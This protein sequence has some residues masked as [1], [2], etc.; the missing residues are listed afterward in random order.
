MSGASAAGPVRDP[1]HDPAPPT[2][3]LQA[4]L[5]GDAAA[6]EESAALVRVVDTPESR[7]RH[8]SDLLGMVVSAVGVTL[9]LVLSVVAHATTEGVTQDVQGFNTLLG[10][11]LF[12]PVQL[13]EGLVVLFVP[14][15]VLIELGVRRL[16]R[17][18]VESICAAA[19]GLLLGIVAGVLVVRLGSDELVRGLSVWRDG[20]WRLTI[21]GYVA[22]IAGLLT[23]AG[24][25]TRRRT[26]RW[27]WNVLYLALF[28]VLITGQVALPGILVALLLGRLAGQAV[29]YVSGV[30]SERA[31]GADLVAA[32]RRAGFR[33]TAL[34]RVRDVSAAAQ[35]EPLDDAVT[36]YDADGEVAGRTTLG[37]LRAPT[38][39]PLGP[40][41]DAAPADPAAVALTRAGDNRVYAM[42]D[43]DGVRRDVVV[44]D[45]DRQVMGAV[46]RVWRALRL[47][48]FEGRAAISLKAAAERTALLSYAAAAA[49][50]RTPRLLGIG[51]ADDSVVLVQEH[52]RGAVSLRD[53]P[54][55]EL[56]G[57]RGDA[58][59]AQAWEQLRRA[60]AA[61]VT[62]HALTPDVVLVSRDGRGDP[63]VW[64]T[65]WEQ[66]E[67]ASGALSRRMDLTQML[68][69][70]ALRVGPRRAIASAVRALP[71]ED[72]AAIG[73]LLQSIALPTA[74]RVEVRRDR[75]LLD[76]LRAALVERLP[77]A[78]VQPQNITRFG[79]RTVV[80]V[81]LTIVAIAVVVTTMNFEEI[82]EA[83]STANPWWVGI[84]F[85]LGA[86][87]WLGAALTFVA[88]SPERL[89]LW[90][91]TLTQM[92]G[93]FVALAAPAGIGPAALNLRMLT[94]RGVT[95][96]MAVA[97][98]G[99]VQ[100]SQFVV[101]V[102]L[103]VVLSIFTG[104]G[105]I[106]ELP[107]TTVLLAITGVALVIVA[108]LLVPP[109]RRWA[110]NRAS[111]ILEQ[112]WPRLS[113]MLGQPTR[114][115]LG[116]G[117]NVVMTLGYVL[118]F[119]AALAAFGRSLSLVDV[120]V[121][122]LVG[123][124]LGAMMPTPG[125]LGGVEGALTAGLTAAGIPA[126]IAF[127]VT[128]LYRLVTYWGRVPIGWVAMRH[129]ER[130][131]DL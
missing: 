63:H 34:V 66:G 51:V 98:V 119:D 77:Q 76:E 46:Q 67:I 3:P 38:A 120:A 110:W 5:A 40:A 1:A 20:G 10:R 92:A 128:I 82:A 57:P 16:G 23:T 131:G 93:S 107:S 130:K 94:R 28:I 50:V 79:A 122:Y 32:V 127:S 129:L 45:G 109:A 6:Q 95:T 117:G 121:I 99:L 31:Y 30:R 9:V 29:Q 111:P 106:V 15:A 91:A 103:L 44:L 26:V 108:V 35:P 56:Q 41:P 70:L 33:P 47:R 39:P 24:P 60:H 27:S 100:V 22:A 83:V 123:N 115:A 25:R 114:L 69:L 13:L 104:S 4:L 14:A 12:V 54:D 61:G 7:V 124:A 112:V 43:D 75:G 80:M 68:A 36:S 48:G 62:H 72:I 64:L 74:T 87:T 73:P 11:I 42:F 2:G 101:T 18:V 86:I 49:G 53:L 19:L 71:D 126:S 8:P 81:T 84:A 125:G 21:P 116:L 58:V 90:R 17:Q 102:L 105:G 113:Q 88:F 55:D 78:D 59:L 52:A 37:S 118:A 97:T 89:P 96:P 65:G 85:A